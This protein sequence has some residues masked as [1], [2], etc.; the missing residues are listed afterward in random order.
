MLTRRDNLAS[1]FVPA[2][3]ER[4]HIPLEFPLATASKGL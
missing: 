3:R 1:R 4:G 2:R